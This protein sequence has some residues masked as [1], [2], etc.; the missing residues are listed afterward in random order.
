VEPLET[1]VTEIDHIEDDQTYEGEIDHVENGVIVPSPDGSMVS[2]LVTPETYQ[3]LII[4]K[5]STENMN[6]AIRRLLWMKAVESTRH[7]RA[8]GKNDLMWINENK[9]AKV[10]VEVENYSRMDK[11]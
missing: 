5:A 1:G 10:P 6:H 4:R 7:F 3:D 2:I 8:A 11:T 9:N